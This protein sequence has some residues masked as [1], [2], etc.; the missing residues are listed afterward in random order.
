MALLADHIR[1]SEA[2]ARVW[3][4]LNSRAVLG[5]GYA[6]A[7]TLTGVAILLAASPPETGPLAPASQLVL[8][9]LSLNLILILALTTV[10]ALRFSALL[11][12]RESDAGARLHLR[13]VTLFALAAVAPAVVVR[14][15]QQDVVHGTK[16]GRTW[17]INPWSLVPMVL[18]LAVEREAGAPPE[19]PRT[20]ATP[21]RQGR[22]A[23]PRT[24]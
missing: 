10:V 22:R 11:N 9:V 2:A 3:R 23:G 4:T 24:E 12:A 17:R 14:M 20:A 8:T 21:R 1:D 5:A 18:A 13:F 19:G 6:V 7:A 15:L 16:V